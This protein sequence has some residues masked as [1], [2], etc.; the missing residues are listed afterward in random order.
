MAAGLTDRLEATW[1]QIHRT[2]RP[3]RASRDRGRKNGGWGW[4]A[5]AIDFTNDGDLD[6]F[7]TNG[8][9]GPHEQEYGDYANDRSRAF[10][11]NGDGTFHDIA[12]RLG[13]DDREFGRG[14]V[15]ADFDTDG[16]VDILLLHDAAT[17]WENRTSGNSF[18]RVELR[19]TAPNTA[20]AGAR[21]TVR[22]GAGERRQTS[23][24]EITI[25]SNVP[26]GRTRRPR[27]SVSAQRSNAPLRWPNGALITG[28]ANPGDTEHL[29]RNDSDVKR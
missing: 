14:V 15:C 23:M 5:C 26:L 25:G 2:G 29:W 21:I 10:E 9:T 11:N 16:D 3:R 7:Q 28:E 12:G 4:A 19:G 8:W 20:A 13:V 18:L 27:C 17:L 24:R 6:I 22:T 1:W